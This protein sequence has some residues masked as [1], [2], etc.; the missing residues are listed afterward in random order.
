MFIGLVGAFMTAAYMTRA[1]YLTFFGEPEGLLP[2]RRIQQVRQVTAHT[3][4]TVHTIPTT[5]T[6]LTRRMAR[7]SLAC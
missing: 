5:I 3:I 6:M 4:H 2:V 1:T 7:T